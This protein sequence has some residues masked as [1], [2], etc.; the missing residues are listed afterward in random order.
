MQK[1][2]TARLEVTMTMWQ[3]SQLCTHH[4]ALQAAN[5]VHRIL[6]YVATMVVHASLMRPWGPSQVVTYQQ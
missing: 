6:D 2:A 5:S 4:A 3:A 1:A